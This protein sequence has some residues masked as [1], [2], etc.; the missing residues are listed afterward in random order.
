[1]SES[2]VSLV[3]HKC[4]FLYIHLSLYKCLCTEPIVCIQV[5]VYR[6]NCVYTSVCVQNPLCVYKCLCT[7]PI[8]LDVQ[9]HASFIMASEFETT[10]TF[11]FMVC[12]HRIS[13]WH[14][15]WHG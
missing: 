12:V 13:C 9:W 3:R 8:V 6:T 2:I 15:N 10:E 7:E 11:L 1:M 14:V 5:S 4:F